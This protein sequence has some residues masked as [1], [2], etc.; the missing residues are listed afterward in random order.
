M[1]MFSVI[2]ILIMQIIFPTL[3]TSILSFGRSSHI[4]PT[5]LQ[6]AHASTSRRTS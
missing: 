2:V 6:Q 5:T 1:L 4:S 3:S